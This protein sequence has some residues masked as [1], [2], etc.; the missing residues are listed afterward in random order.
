[1]SCGVTKE[2][3][4]LKDNMKAQVD[5]LTKEFAG[6]AEAGKGL[7]DQLSGLKSKVQGTIESV[8]ADIL[9]AVPPIPEPL[10]KLQDQMGGFLQNPTDPG[11]FVTKI[12]EM[13]E[14]FGTDAL[15]SG[16][17]GLGID[18]AAVN[19]QLDKFNQ[20]KE[21]GNQAL[22]S[23]SQGALDL[24]NVPKEVTDAIGIAQ[25][26]TSS[27]T[28]AFSKSISNIVPAGFD[29]SAALDS[30]CSSVPNVEITPEG[31]AVTKGVPATVPSKDAEPAPP[32]EPP[33]DVPPPAVKQ[34]NAFVKENKTVQV[35]PMTRKRSDI[36]QAY[37]DRVTIASQ[38]AVKATSYKN[39]I[40][41]AKKENVT[42]SQDVVDQFNSW[43][44]YFF[45]YKAD[46]VTELHTEYKNNGLEYKENLLEPIKFEKLELEE[47]VKVQQVRAEIL[48][49][50]YVLVLDEASEE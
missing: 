34:T 12:N 9:A 8:S 19:K 48:A 29:P 4:A 31:V 42:P 35:V 33:K 20:L 40:E 46:A 16:L 5:G 37:R 28:N 14:K 44:N 18:P 7:L 2:I 22:E 39:I 45:V 1:M 13:A 47:K 11:S 38:I 21:K 50:K 27:I 41:N 24:F 32:P 17:S 26:D 30:L 36:F 6:E 10:A 49:L 3:Q 25:G 23:I 43:R 15:N